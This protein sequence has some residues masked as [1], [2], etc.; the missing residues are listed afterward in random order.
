MDN[1]IIHKVEIKRERGDDFDFIETLH[2]IKNLLSTNFFN[3]LKKISRS[4]KVF[5]R[6]RHQEKFPII[7]ISKH[8]FD[9]RY[10]AILVQKIK[11]VLVS[12]SLKVRKK[13]CNFNSKKF[14]KNVA[15]SPQIF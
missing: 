14:R 7:E 6:N 12:V 1:S 5:H 2:E 3:N 4:F 10:R 15:K 11:L 8:N 9:T 13:S